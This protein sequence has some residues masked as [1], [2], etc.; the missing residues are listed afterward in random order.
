MAIVS[1][2]AWAKV[3][4]PKLHAEEFRADIFLRVAF[5]RFTSGAQNIFL[6]WL[7]HGPFFYSTLV[8]KSLGGR[9][10]RVAHDQSESR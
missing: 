3:V 6:F 7:C 9:N 2:Q 8:F 4:K 1:S 10:E 5:F